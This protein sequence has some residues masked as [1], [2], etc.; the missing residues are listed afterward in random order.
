VVTDLQSVERQSLK[1][2]LKSAWAVSAPAVV[3]FVLLISFNAVDLLAWTGLGRLGIGALLVLLVGLAYLFWKGRFWAAVPAVLAFGSGLAYFLMSFFRVADK[4]LSANPGQYWE[5]FMMCAPHLVII[6]ICLTLIIVVIKGMK[7]SWAIGPQPLSRLFVGVLLLWMLALGGDAWYQSSGWRSF[8]LASDLMVRMCQGD[9][10]LRREVQSRLLSLGPE[11]VPDLLLGVSTPDPDL[12][13]L[14]EHSSQVVL[15]FG[16]Q[17]L[18]PLL[19]AAKAGDTGAVR[20]LGELGDKRAL[21]H[22]RGILKDLKADSP[23]ELRSTLQAAIG[24]LKG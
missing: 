2:L 6:T 24:K 17:A 22:L 16:K 12:G 21:A 4:Y 5:L 10:T 23:D 13:C 19:D 15:A 3:P 20:L 1:Y 18:D 14:R 9:P 7:L 8:N 11:V